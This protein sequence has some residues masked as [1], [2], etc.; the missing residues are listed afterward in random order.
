MK[1]DLH[2]H[3][4]WSYD[5]FDSPEK[6]IVSALE[7]GLDGIALTDHDT[8]KGW[9]EA[10]A[11]AKKHNAVLVL[12]QE[13]KTEKC[14]L[15]GLFL[16]KEVKSKK[17]LEA[18]AEIRSQGGIA[19]VA[20]PYHFPEN[21]KGKLEEYLKFVDGIEVFNSRGP[22]LAS[23]NKARRL[24][25]KCGTAMTAGSDSHFGRTS[26]SAY[27]Q[28]E[29]AD[30]EEFKQAII[31]KKTKTFGKKLN[32]IYLLAPLVSRLASLFFPNWRKK[33]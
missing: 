16:T 33:K 10:I 27:A 9:P 20:H 22:F 17:F 28:A 11:A 4:Y 32:R 14:D 7:K 8:I 26:G 2:N 15:L 21:F 19:I 30:I 1:I 23:D 24:A 31:G 29:A 6:L 18:A 5:G 3:S 25:E 12:G 13:I